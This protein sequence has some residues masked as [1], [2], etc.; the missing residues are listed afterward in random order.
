MIQIVIADDH[1]LFRE[2][3]GAL[4]QSQGGIEVVALCQDSTEAIETARADNPHLML[5]D[6]K[7]TP[8]SG[9]ATATAIAAFSSTKMIGLSMYSS[10]TYAKRMFKAGAKGYITKNAS[11]HEIVE[12]IHKVMNGE[13]YLSQEIKDLMAEEAMQADSD[14]PV[15][16]TLTARELEVVRL[17]SQGY[18]SRQIATAL[19]VTFKTIEAHRHNMLQK[20]QL[21]NS[22]ELINY[23]NHHEDY[24]L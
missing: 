8:L 15:A 13:K 23:L 18:S 19:G 24:F 4:L 21:K 17:I 14:K 22:N 5:L 11:V 3:L 2:T 6:M 1:K 16:A 20:L 7:M 10:T 9:I 12:G